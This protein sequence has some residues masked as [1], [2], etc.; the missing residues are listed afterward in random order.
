VLPGSRG[1]TIV[2]IRRS[3]GVPETLLILE[4]MWL[5]GGQDSLGMIRGECTSAPTIT[6][7]SSSR[8][9][10]ET[11]RPTRP[12]STHTDCDNIQL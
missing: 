8:R 9:N 1:E 4:Q 10:H 3:G 11:W 2:S 7:F 12:H 6:S 5:G